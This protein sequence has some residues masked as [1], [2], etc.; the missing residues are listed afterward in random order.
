MSK[1]TSGY[2]SAGADVDSAVTASRLIMYAATAFCSYGKWERSNLAARPTSDTMPVET[3]SVC[4][5][6]R[7]GRSR[8]GAQ[9]YYIG[10]M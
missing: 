1:Y 10:K 9:V 4:V 5:W 7:G 3:V 6:D 8:A 2:K